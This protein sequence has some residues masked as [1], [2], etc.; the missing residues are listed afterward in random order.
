MSSNRAISAMLVTCLGVVSLLSGCG[1]AAN[2]AQ[3]AANAVGNA[4]QNTVNATGNAVQ[5]TVNAVGNAAQNTANVAG[6]ATAATSPWMTVNA[7]TKTVTFLLIAGYNNAD[8]GFNFNGYTN[9]GMTFTV[10][11]G[12]TVKINFQ[13]NSTVPHS[14]VVV[15]YNKRSADTPAIPGASSPNPEQ[16]VGKG[17]KQTFSFKAVTAG[18]YAIVC[19]VPGHEEAGMWITFVVSDT[20]TAPSVTTS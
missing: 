15:P 9:G 7:G 8:G 10:P 2:T 5:N 16:G 19:A 18:K 20:A 1:G 14:A 6:G 11:K 17:V 12:W 13:N 4:V 3:N